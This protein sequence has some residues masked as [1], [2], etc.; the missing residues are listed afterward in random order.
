MT[1]N[2]NKNKKSQG[3][4]REKSVHFKKKTKRNKQTKNY[5]RMF[6][7]RSSVVLLLILRGIFDPTDHIAVNTGKTTPAPLQIQ[8][9]LSKFE[10][11]E[12]LNVSVPA[13]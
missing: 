2:K 10:N 8:G 13:R 12:Y 1:K 6:T 7:S 4:K 5:V 11:V 3:H 9:L